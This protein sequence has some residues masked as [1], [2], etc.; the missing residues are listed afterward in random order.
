M[1]RNF[2]ARENLDGFKP[3][4]SESGDEEAPAG[5]RGFVSPG[6]SQSFRAPLWPVSAGALRPR[7]LLAQRLALH[8][9]QDELRKLSA[10]GLVTSR[11]NGFHRY[12]EANRRHPLYPAICQIVAL[13]SQLP[14]ARVGDLHRTKGKRSSKRSRKPRRAYLKGPYE[15][16]NWGTSKGILTA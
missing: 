7:A 14:G 12:Y 11:S 15:P 9:I 10:L 16:I 2:E 3:S 13:S 6:A 5:G 1:Q 4:R 8:T